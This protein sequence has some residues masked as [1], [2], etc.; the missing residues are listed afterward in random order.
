MKF[1][2]PDSF[3][4]GVARFRRQSVPQ[5]EGIYRRASRTTFPALPPSR[6]QSVP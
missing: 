2:L 5:I 4:F 6:Q 3:P 1:G